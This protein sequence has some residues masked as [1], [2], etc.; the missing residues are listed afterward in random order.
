MEG[1][2]WLDVT[3]TLNWNRPAVG[4]IRV[5]SECAAYFIS[6][7]SP[8]NCFCRFDLQSKQYLDVDPADVQK[9]LDKIRQG[10]ISDAP[11][12][13]PSSPTPAVPS[14]GQWI[15]HTVFRVINSMPKKLRERAHRFATKRS[16]MFY[17]AM[18]SYYEFRLAIR[19]FIS[20]GSST[21]PTPIATEEAES[22]QPESPF[23]S[24]DVYISLGLD[25]DDKDYEY[26]F[27]EKKR[28]NFK[29]LLFCYDIIPVKYPH[30][31]FA[32]VASRFAHYFA[33]LAWCADKVLCIS[34]CTRRD[35]T[36]LLKELGSPLP[37]MSVIK[38]GCDIPQF[39]NQKPAPE[40]LEIAENR[41]ILFVST[42]ERRKNHEVLYRAYTRLVDNGTE[43]L[44]L[45]V[46]VGMPGWGV[47]EL[48]SDLQLDRR[49]K[50]YIRILNYVSDSD[51]QYLYQH[52]IFTVFPSLYEG[53][54]IPVAESLANGKFCLTSNAASMPEVGED[55]VEYL[56]PWDLP[57]WI[58]RLKWYFNH[59][60]EVLLKE[61][62]IRREYRPTPWNETA[63][64]V[65][66]HA[67]DLRAVGS[68]PLSVTSEGKSVI[69]LP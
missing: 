54:G 4:I 33:N 1:R 38:L 35:L 37:H 26:L 19:E 28:I 25:W 50:P 44:P 3:T 29:V 67:Q 42:I 56:D 65:L 31:F 51:L 8:N 46:F 17:A 58:E 15:K 21:T 22:R 47:N 43:K 30:L 69:I 68:R 18:R 62:R 66:K 60:E 20:P 16:V 36:E 59:P 52:A 53:W 7:N 12:A 40:V 13:P 64:L 39:N 11:P 57:S 34:D 48:L 32:D 2:I 10:R 49:T 41:F 61:Q 45:L 23:I 27:S 9:A 14:A 55:F 6:A 24:G 5:E 63:S